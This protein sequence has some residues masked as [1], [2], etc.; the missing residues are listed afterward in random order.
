[1]LMETAGKEM[2]TRVE[3]RRR[4]KVTRDI[5]VTAEKNLMLAGSQ[6]YKE[7]SDTVHVTGDCTFTIKVGKTQIKMENNQIEMLAENAIEFEMSGRNAFR[8]GTSKQDL[9]EGGE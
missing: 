7:T 8:T 4:L 9:P 5:T 2:I 3:D 1:M 6:K